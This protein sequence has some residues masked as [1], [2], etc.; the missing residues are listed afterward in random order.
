MRELY[1]S[2][3]VGRRV[4]FGASSALIIV[5]FQQSY[6]RTWRAKNLTPVENTRRLLDAARQRAVPVVYTYMG[7]DP[8][9]PDAGV[10]A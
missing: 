3:G 9:H 1:R 2:H 8:E 7:Y 6:T 4:G 10:W 5:D